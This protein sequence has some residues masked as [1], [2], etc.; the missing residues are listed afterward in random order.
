MDVTR[1]IGPWARC[2]AVGTALALLGGGCAGIGSRGSRSDDVPGPIFVLSLSSETGRAAVFRIDLGLGEARPLWGQEGQALAPA[3]AVGPE[4]QRIYVA[5]RSS[6]TEDRL[7][8]VD[9][10]TGEILDRETFSGL[11]AVRSPVPPDLLAAVGDHVFVY[12]TEVTG[13]D[14]AR[15][16]VRTY[17]ALEGRF[18]PEV[19]ELGRCGP[20][21]F[22][23]GGGSTGIIVICPWTAQ[24][25]VVSVSGSGAPASHPTID[26][27]GAEG[28]PT[29]TVRPSGRIAAADVSPDGRTLYV[30][31]ESALVFTVDLSG[32][33]VASV[34]R[35]GIAQDAYAAYGSFAVSSDGGTVFVGTGDPDAFDAFRATSLS[36]L[37]VGG[38]VELG[39]FQ[40][41]V[42]FDRV[43]PLAG[44]HAGLL[45]RATNAVAEVDVEGGR[46]VRSIALP[47][48][49]VPVDIVVPRAS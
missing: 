17:D 20:G 19:V 42:A 25:H 29:G 7:D 27:P 47:P 1:S 12:R 2:V 33:R 32:A 13:S 43:V 26:L 40:P 6:S 22:L 10:V 39:R 28:G 34:D 21:A 15:D 44:G 5:Y 48:G 14:A 8:V 31:T 24:V 30:V 35:L 18:L 38:W 3:V 11:A 23:F 41:K 46:L 16:P 49:A 9:A 37:S 45:D 4:Q 36:Q